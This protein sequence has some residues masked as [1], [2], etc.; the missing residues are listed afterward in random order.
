VKLI[1]AQNGEK[2][3]YTGCAVLAACEILFV[4]GFD[5]FRGKWYICSI[6]C[7][8][9]GVL[10]GSVDVGY[11]ATLAGKLIYSGMWDAHCS[12]QHSS[13]ASL[14]SHTFSHDVS[15]AG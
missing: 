8:T 14:C 7:C 1:I 4:E 9:F 5:W 11:D 12:A 2:I 10:W 15:K 13:R 6:A 3:T